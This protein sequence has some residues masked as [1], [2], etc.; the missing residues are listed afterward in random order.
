MTVA[1]RRS[2]HW[3]VLSLFGCLMV[4][5]A[6][7]LTAQPAYAATPSSGT[8][9]TTT[10]NVTWCGSTGCSAQINSVTSSPL[11]SDCTNSTCDVYTLTVGTVSSNSVIA[12]KIQ[13]TIPTNDFDLHVYDASGNE[14]CSSTNGAPETS[15]ACS[16]PA[17]AGTYTIK[18]LEWTVAADNFVGTAQLQA[19]PAPATPSY[20]TGGIT[21]SPNV[22]VKAPVAARDGEPSNRTDY[23]GNA[24]VG[25]IRGFPAGVDL[26]KFD[27][28]PSSATYDANLMNPA[29][30]GQPDA[31]PTNSLFDVGADGGGDIDL[32]VG[33]QPPAVGNGLPTVAEVSLIAAN[34]SASKSTDQGSTFTLDPAGSYIPADDRQWIEFYKGDTVFMLYRAP[35]PAT[36]LWVATSIDGGLTYPVTSSLNLSG[37]TPGYISVDQNTGW[38]Y[39][40]HENSSALMVSRA[41]FD[42]ANPLTPLSF[43][44]ATVDNTT[45]HAHLF[46]SVK[47]GHDG[48]VYALWSD[49]HNIYYSYSK[50]HGQTW[51]VKAQV[52]NPNFTINDRFGNPQTVKTNIFP[53]MEAGSAGR[54]DFVWFATTESTNNDNA[55]WVVMFAQATNANTSTPAIRQVVASDHFIHAGNVSEMG[56]GGASNRNLLDYFQV[57]LD[58]QG[59]AMIAFADDHN[60]FTGHTYVTHQISGPSAYSAANGTGTVKT[61]AAAKLPAQNPNLPQVTDFRDDVGAETATVPGD[62]AWDITSIR[63]GC[64]AT[65]DGGTML[66]AAMSLSSLATIPPE[67][68]WR[69]NFSGNAVGGLSDRGDQFFLLA[70]TETTTPTFTWGT[71]TRNSDGSFTYTTR[72]ATDVGYFDTANNQVVMKVNLNQLNQFASKPL[73]IGSTLIG[74]R[75]ST[76]EIPITVNNAPAVGTTSVSA[77]RDITRGGSIPI[78]TALQ[79]DT[80]A[81]VGTASYTIGN[82]AGAAMQPPPPPPPGTQKVA[83]ESGDGTI[84]AGASTGKFHFDVDNGP[85]GQLTY[86]D[87]AA[88]IDLVST[89]ITSFVPP[90]G[91][92]CVSF[93]GNARLNGDA[94]HIFTVKACDNGNNGATDTFTINIDSNYSATGTLKSGN[95]N[96]HEK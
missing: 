90:S 11:S 28:N 7:V 4:M 78:G 1:R 15:E 12:V 63:Y 43:A 35:I 9:S 84:A 38:V 52:S 85:G 56:L 73:G 93:T 57:S 2:W 36:P 44:T 42:P 40:A 48:T 3:Q 71:A 8:I 65:V 80:V 10:P 19:A 20:T 51:S 81:G 18:A 96:I 53:W 16:F 46:D 33:F 6:V 77:P 55:D 34:I 30:K 31:F 92:S 67:S 60:D 66:T 59:G 58:P 47:V 95:I 26:W 45:S 76:F 13:W 50:D 68:N 32:A 21:F 89:S 23:L 29:Y 49:D 79:G 69:I 82:C 5:T 25:A 91:D 70:T 62:N 54:V 22:T 61:V 72:A 83:S 24:Y 74:L 17:V 86:S 14:V 88:G 39:A 87:K 27:L 94:G 41:L 37:T 64:Q 75:G